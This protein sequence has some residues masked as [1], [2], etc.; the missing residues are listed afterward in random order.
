MQTR[1]DTLSCDLMRPGTFVTGC[2]YWASHAGTA[3]WRDWR[4]DVVEADLRQLSQGGLDVLRVFPLW[5]DFQPLALLRGCR[6][7]AVEFR[8]GEAPLAPDEA[9]QAGVSAQAMARFAQFADLA[10]EAGLQLIVGLITG[11]MSGRLHVP[12]A[13]EGRNVMTDPTAVMWQVRFAR[14]F[15]RRFKDHPAVLAWEPGN[16]CNC[17]GS[18]SS[19]EEAWLWTSSITNAIRGADPSRPIVSGMHGLSPCGNLAFNVD[20]HAFW[21]IRDQAEL[22]DVLTTHP[23]PIFVPHCDQDPINTVRTGMHAIAESRL[24][25]DIGNRPCLTEEVG[26]LGPMMCS[27]RVAADYVRNLLFSLWAHDCHGLLWWCAYDQLELKHAPYDWASIERELGLFRSDRS[28]KPIAGEIGK[29][30]AFLR[31]L[32]VKTLPCR[33]TEAVCILTEGQDHWGAAYSSF[34]LAK[35]AGFDVVFR[36]ADQDLG[37]GNLY[38]LPSVSGMTALSGRSWTQLLARVADG[39]TLYLSH[40]DCLLAPVGEVLGVEV[41]TR[42]R[43]ARAASVS[44]EA[45][46]GSPALSVD[47]PIKLR[48][49]PTTAEVLGREEDGNPCFT[50]TEYGKGRIYFLTVP[51]ELYLSN[52]P[53][54]FHGE[55]AQPFREIYRHVAEPFTRERIVTRNHP[56]VGVTEHALG[57]NERVV[58]LINYAPAPVETTVT[59]APGW[60]AVRS[61][62]GAGPK[63]DRCALAGNDAAVFTVAR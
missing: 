20:P 17:M 36:Y 54:A 2:N 21:T 53:G 51:I 15:V 63:S 5:P 12:A 11:W 34:I 55:S 25:A 44:M 37:D 58:V 32:P 45:L 35:Q 62:Y 46:P 42:E 40:N 60:K 48:L 3:M 31:G 52:T 8:L 47:C 49:V 30:A 16:E 1:S 9:G 59:L 18:V 23:Y 19:R 61:W 26:T 24:Y 28:A 22:T 41:Q 29:F 43:R 13:L 57:E 14:H 10:H 7:A 50:C 4:P 56:L 27:E 33:N 39:A 6:G 38:L